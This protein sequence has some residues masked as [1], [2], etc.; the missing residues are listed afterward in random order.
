M[1]SWHSLARA[2][3]VAALSGA[4]Y[5][6]AALAMN[7]LA[8]VMTKITQNENGGYS[9]NKWCVYF[10][11]ELIKLTVACIWS[12]HLKRTGACPGLRRR[13]PALPSAKSLVVVRLGRQIQLPLAK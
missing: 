1:D 4:M 9:Y 3:M 2:A 7:T 10:F 8:P 6:G 12:W 13:V 5:L 11:A